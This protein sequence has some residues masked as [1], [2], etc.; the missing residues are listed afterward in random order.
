M[1]LTITLNPS[2][3]YT[4][5]VRSLLVGDTN[6]VVR[7]EVDAGGKGINLSR[8]TAELG[9]ESVATGFL[10][11]SPGDFVRRVL[12]EQGVRDECVPIAGETRRN[13]NVE[14]I[15]IETPP[16]TLNSQGEAISGDDWRTLCG[17]VCELAK[18]AGWVAMGGSLPPMVAVDAY[19]ELLECARGAGAK[20]LVDADGEPM[21]HALRV[22]PD[23][24]K[25]NAKEAA[26][27]VGYEINTDADAIRAAK[28][29]LEN[30]NTGG[31]VV[32]SRGHQGAVLA[33][34]HGVWLGR[35]PEVDAKSTIGAGDS[36]LGG[37]LAQLVK[38]AAPEE[39]L[40][41][42]LAAGA[43]TATTDGTQ[44]GRRAVIEELL[45]RAQ[46]EAAG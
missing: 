29:L 38:G 18:G 17:K 27:L 34:A 28:D 43:A 3:D 10:G 21:R 14:S 5:F 30:V 37:F 2:L 20:V 16:T 24:L 45:A 8:I 44:I 31:M 36:F 25:P 4:L 39:A 23:L 13:F 15:D 33:T 26:R 9:V 40:R 35:S 7:Q 46:V 32:V 41:W 12:T 11:G 22:R 1:V 42:G 19:E 6:R